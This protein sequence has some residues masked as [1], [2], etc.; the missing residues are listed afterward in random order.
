MAVFRCAGRNRHDEDGNP[1]CEYE[2]TR[3]WLGNCPGC[4][5]PYNVLK[6]GVDKKPDA[7][8]VTLGSLGTAKIKPR[9]K[10]N[11]EPFDRVL[12]G[13]IPEGSTVII[14][15]PPGVGKTSILLMVADAAAVGKTKVTYIAGEQNQNDLAEYAQRLG[16][17]S[18]N[19]I[20]RATQSAIDIDSTLKEVEEDE[21]ELIIIDSLQTCLSSNSKGDAGTSDQCKAVANTLTEWA[22]QKGVAVILVSHVNKAGDL[23][24]PKAAEH[25]VDGTL[26]FD[27]APEMD[28]ND[29]PTEETKN[30]RKLTSGAKFRLG[31]SGES[32]M[33]EMTNEGVKPI[34]KKSKLI[35]LNDDGDDGD[36]EPP[37]PKKTKLFTV[38]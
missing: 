28:R 30:W 35:K 32:E 12:N 16:V 21:S 5:R 37:K 13:G 31:P 7:V 26:E 23:A 24:G 3:H 38:V 6:V 29:E 25:L 14:S 22:K 36:D 19:V 18:N 2:A 10:T 4:G 33:F 17:K 11:I 15:G 34:K 27:P 9:V 20:V 1:Y 8:R